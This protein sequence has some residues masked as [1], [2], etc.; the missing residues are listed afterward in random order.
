MELTKEQRTTARDIISGMKCPADFECYKST[1]EELPK[2]RLVVGGQLVEC[3]ENG[4]NPCSFAVR[5][6]SGAFCECPLLNYMAKSLW[7]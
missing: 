2:H 7:C 3:L 6:G 4:H 1:F 5:Y